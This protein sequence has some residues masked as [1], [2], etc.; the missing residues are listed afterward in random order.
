MFFKLMLLLRTLALAVRGELRTNSCV[1]L[2]QS[3]A[4]TLTCAVMVLFV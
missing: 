2:R 1:V 3:S 4:E